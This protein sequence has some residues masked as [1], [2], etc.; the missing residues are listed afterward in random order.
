M[1]GTGTCLLVALLERRLSVALVAPRGKVRQSRKG[2]PADCGYR[3]QL[4]GDAQFIIS[5]VHLRSTK[6]HS[7]GH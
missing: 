7:Q 2:R 3:A 5:V 4:W 1:D 6:A